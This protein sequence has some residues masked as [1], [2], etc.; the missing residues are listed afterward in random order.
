MENVAHIGKPGWSLRKKKKKG[1]ITPTATNVQGRS[2]LHGQDMGKTQYHR[3]SIE[4]CLAVGGWQVVA[5]G[6]G[7]RLAVDGPWGLS[8]TKKRGGVLKDSPAVSAGAQRG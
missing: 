1:F 8:L 4:Q 3:S 5:V 7:W 6:G 2:L